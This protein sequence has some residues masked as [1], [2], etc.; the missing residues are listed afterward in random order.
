MPFFHAETDTTIHFFDQDQTVQFF[1]EELNQLHARMVKRDEFDEVFVT[2]INIQRKN[3]I[4]M[5]QCYPSL[6]SSSKVKLIREFNNCMR[7]LKKLKN[8]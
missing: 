4:N 3:I 1:L 2:E 6:C 8:K 5:D 7:T